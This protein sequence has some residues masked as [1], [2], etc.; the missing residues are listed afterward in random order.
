MVYETPPK[1]SEVSVA[2]YR[3]LTNQY[4]FLHIFWRHLILFHDDRVH[5][6]WQMMAAGSL[7]HL[8]SC[9]TDA[10]IPAHLDITLKN[11]LKIVTN[12]FSILLG[13]GGAINRMTKNSRNQTL[14]LQ[15]IPSNITESQRNLQ[16]Q[17]RTSMHVH[18]MCLC[19]KIG[20]RLISWCIMVC[21]HFPF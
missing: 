5:D 11:S 1:L 13:V 14:P 3:I 16:L 12:Y 18:V 21:H 10:E 4:S 8:T 7:G 9:A 20:Y 17:G 19:P 6:L 15:R 2:P